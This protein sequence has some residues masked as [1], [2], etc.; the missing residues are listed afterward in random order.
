MDDTLLPNPDGTYAMPEVVW[1]PLGNLEPGA[2]YRTQFRGMEELEGSIRQFGVLSP[3]WVEPHPTRENRYVIFAGRRRYEAAKKIARERCD[4]SLDATVTAQTGQYIVPCRIFR[5]L[6]EIHQAL[7]ALTE[8]SARRDPS[9]IDTAR[10]LGRIKALLEGKMGHPIK[11]DEIVGMLC[12]KGSGEKHLGKR[13]AYRLLRI[14]ELDPGVAAVAKERHLASDYLD[15]VARL[16]TPEDQLELI[17]TIGDLHLGRDQVRQVVNRRQ[18]DKDSKLATLVARVV[19]ASHPS[20]EAAVQGTLDLS[21]RDEAPAEAQGRCPCKAGSATGSNSL[22]S[23]RP[24]ANVAVDLETCLETLS[25]VGL[26]E[27]LRKQADVDLLR[28]GDLL[29]AWAVSEGRLGAPGGEALER[30]ISD[31]PGRGHDAGA[32]ERLRAIL[33]GR[34]YSRLEVG[35]IRLLY[36]YQG[37]LPEHLPGYLGQTREAISESAWYQRL[38]WSFLELL[39]LLGQPEE[40]KK[41]NTIAARLIDVAFHEL[42][43]LATIYD[44]R[45]QYHVEKLPPVIKKEFEG[46]V[47]EHVDIVRLKAERGK[48]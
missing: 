39:A 33:Q 40:G 46:V 42:F 37:V 13:H 22:V 2:G 15:Q 28:A 43:W 18:S 21:S 4:P 1:I 20:S 10:E 48:G 34:E 5:H 47:L 17:D 6:A 27:G 25:L 41:V 23:A 38:V 45:L 35:V 14:A 7:L 3:L 36:M 26:I 32:T 44:P 24:G 19:A 8:N 16:S 9:A 11:V 12:G 30:W 29:E 31:L